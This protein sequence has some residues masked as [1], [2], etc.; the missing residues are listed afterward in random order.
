MSSNKRISF[1]SHANR[2]NSDL[3]LANL[4]TPPIGVNQ[5][6]EGILFK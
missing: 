5:K 3:I 2:R 4:I 1:V 6:F